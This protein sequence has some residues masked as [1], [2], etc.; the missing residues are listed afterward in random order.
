MSK[1]TGSWLG[2]L[3][4]GSSEEQELDRFSIEHLRHLREVLIRNPVVT[5]ANRDAIVETLRSIAELMVWGDQHDP[6]FLDYFLENNILQHFTHILQ[7][8][9]NRRGE[10]AVQVLQTLS[11]LIQNIQSKTAIFYLFSNNHINEVVGMRFDFENE[12]VLGHYITLLKSISL[13]LNNNTV[14][15]FFSNGLFPLYTEAVKLINH[16]DGMV[17]TA[18]R[19]LTLKVYHIRDPAVQSFVISQPANHYFT[20]LASYVADQ[21]QVLDDLLALLGGGSST[22]IYN[23]DSCLAEVEDLLSYCNDILSAGANGLA[24]LV[25]QCLW[26]SFA[27]P[28][29]VEPLVTAVGSSQQGPQL[30]QVKGDS[31]LLHP[32]CALHV[33]ER[34]LHIMSYTPFV[35]LLVSLLCP[36]PQTSMNISPD[37]TPSASDQASGRA[38]DRASSGH[39]AS[40]SQPDSSPDK[41][42]NPPAQHHAEA[43]PAANGVAGRPP[44]QPS[45]WQALFALHEHSLAYRECF[46][47]VLHGEDSQLTAAAVRAL[48]AVVQSKAVS[49]NVLSAC[50]QCLLILSL[51]LVFSYLFPLPTA[52]ARTNCL[53]SL[54]EL[55]FIVSACCPFLLS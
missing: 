3:L 35:D 24:S 32:V 38:T 41:H 43:A 28:V 2:G 26:E 37:A 14:Q 55:L 7:Q 12:E 17:R 23:V 22:A 19:T 49:E 16:R 45:P 25:L 44:P 42:S 21:C 10:V 36:P 33:L 39:S 11:M 9:S 20:R 48:V 29:I 34:L 1:R 18:V 8:R 27:L 53:L 54:L 51:P 40:T 47:A 13:K 4:L 46:L 6:K 52:A 31:K 30:Q 5:D 50:G 15:F